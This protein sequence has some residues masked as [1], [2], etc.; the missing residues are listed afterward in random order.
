MRM[1]LMMI[2]IVSTILGLNPLKSK[3]KTFTL[4][5]ESPIARNPSNKTGDTISPAGRAIFFRSCSPCHKD[6]T[7]ARAPAFDVLTT[8]TARSIL[9]ALNKG[10]M[11]AQGAT[12]TDD[13]KLAVSQWIVQKNVTQTVIDPSA[14]TSF[15]ITESQNGNFDYSGWGANLESTGFRTASQSGIS[16][17][18]VS[19]L[20]LKWAFAFPVATIV[21]SKPAVIG[22]WLIVGSQYGE[23]YAINKRTGK[24]GW[25]FEASAAI[26][27]A[28]TVKREAGA[29]TAYFA[30]FSSNVYAINVRT[31][32]Q[33]WNNRAG[34]EPQSACTGSVVVFGGKVFVPITSIEV[35]SAAYGSYPCCSS[36]GGLVALDAATGTELWRHRVIESPAKESGKKSNGKPFYGPSGAPVWCSPTI[37]KKRGLVFIGT[38]ENYSM[39]STS[40]SDAI[41]ALD[42]KTGK[43]VWNFQATGGDMYNLACPA[44]NN[45]PGQGGPDL[46]F[47]MAPILV[48]TSEGK[49][50]LVAGQKS[51]MV[52]AFS[53][54][55]GTLLWKTRIGKGGALGG[56]HWGMCSD[57]KLVFAANADNMIAIDKRDSSVKASPGL[58]ALDLRSGKQVWKTASPPCPGNQDCL[59]FNSAAP[60]VVPGIVFAGTLDGHIRAYATKDGKILWDFDTAIPFETSDG[61]KGHGGAL[62]GPAPVVSEGMLFV[63]SGYGMFGE[64]PGNVLLA[65]KTGEK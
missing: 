23:L 49:E 63:N 2:M 36:S 22:E 55:T 45:C 64:L 20:K 18:N 17:A 37:D 8:M 54:G 21:R 14:Y 56:I 30:D 59:A 48:R 60:S 57:G 40:T 62:D 65:F 34:F 44:L 13:Q 61:L 50:I 33:I 25:K 53:P 58:F 29:V 15:S 31:G 4:T 16:T 47:G 27:G 11:Q 12:L 39:P 24:L 35:A 1:L 41:Q 52:Y 19:S 26:R 3:E 32:K 7:I 28:I 5:Y 43:L 9:F 38:G 42:M 46:D 10:K 6:S 51:G